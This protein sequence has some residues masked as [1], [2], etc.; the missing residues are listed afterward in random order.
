MKRGRLGALLLSVATL[1]GLARAENPFVRM[2]TSLGA[3]DIELCAEA[4]VRC[5]GDA[6]LSVANF[7]RYVDEDRYPA[8]LFVDLSVTSPNQIVQ[9][10]SNFIGEEN[11]ESIIETV[12]KFDPVPLEAG[13]GLSNLRGTLAVARLSTSLASGTS[14]FYFNLSDNPVFDAQSGGF[15][16]FG[17]VIAG[18]EALDAIGEVPVY[19]ECTGN[20]PIPLIDYPGCP[21]SAI[22][23]LVYVPSIERVPESGTAGAGVASALALAW[24][25][26]RREAA[27]GGRSHYLPRP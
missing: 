23:H 21:A 3:I 12:E 22:P 25:R 16:V 4:S 24:L 15:A 2:T 7:L 17:V 9:S 10:G 6:P 27:S 26:R 18:L 5:S 20:R 1:P 11:G 13:R 14:G 19:P 8:T